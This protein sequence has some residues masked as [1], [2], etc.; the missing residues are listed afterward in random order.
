MGKIITLADHQAKRLLPGH[1]E[2]AQQ[3]AF[4][5][6]GRAVAA[7][8]L[9][10]ASSAGFH[11]FG[12]D[13]GEAVAFT[14]SQ[15]AYTESQVWERLYLPMQCEEFVP[16]TS[17]GGPA[18]DTIRYEIVDYTGQAAPNPGLGTDV[19]YAD[20]VVGEKIFKVKGAAVGYRYTHQELLAAALLR[21]PV[22]TGRQE[23]AI[24][25]YQRDV[26]NVALY[27][28]TVLNLP[29]FFQHPSVG[30]GNAPTGNWL[31]SATPD[32]ILS[33]VNVG[34]NAVWVNTNYNS[35]TTHVV[36]PAAVYN[37]LASTPRSTYSDM[38]ILQYL[39]ENNI[40]KQR[41]GTNVVFAPGFGL[42]TAGAGS[43]KRTIFYE[44]SESN[45][46]MHITQPLSFLAPQ[47]F[48]LEIRVPGTFRYS[49]VEWRYP[50]TGYYMDN[51]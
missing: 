20:M 5:A 15:L 25:T 35:M 12:A 22:P 43:S 17:E 24:R 14:V 50:K 19:P 4:D 46:K 32:Q 27:G 3:Q 16:I 31:T 21:K 28:S 13:A 2:F 6:L 7:A 48:G 37:K 45:L 42:E 49:G 9:P 23:A 26:N 47:L 40:A 33:D 18:V 30:S 11:V 36:M 29:G 34:I 8:I 1:P 39:Q 10:H 38:T 41:K 44:K 51:C